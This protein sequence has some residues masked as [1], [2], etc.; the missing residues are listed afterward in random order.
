MEPG[1]MVEHT[2]TRVEIHALRMAVKDARRQGEYMTSAFL[3]RG[4]L[5]VWRIA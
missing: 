4:L 2:G 1:E 3:K 5:Q